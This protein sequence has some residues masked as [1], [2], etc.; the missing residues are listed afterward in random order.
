MLLH[1]NPSHAKFFLAM[2][3]ACPSFLLKSYTVLEDV[4]VSGGLW[5]WCGYVSS[6]SSLNRAD[7]LTIKPN[8]RRTVG[9]L[10]NSQMIMRQSFFFGNHNGIGPEERIHH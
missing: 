4:G 5:V 2:P 6:S 3:P 8:Y 10:P 9:E 1:G 7:P